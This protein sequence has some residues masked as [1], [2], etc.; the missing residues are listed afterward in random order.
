MRQ[1]PQNVIILFLLLVAELFSILSLEK[2]RERKSPQ[3]T[4]I[5]ISCKISTSSSGSPQY[6]PY[7]SIR[8]HLQR[9]R[10]YFY[11]AIANF[12]TGMVLEPIALGFVVFNLLDTIEKR[13]LQCCGICSYG[14]QRPYFCEK[15]NV[16]NRFCSP[17]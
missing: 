11:K 5:M 16:V 8:A 9:G 14:R 13:L 1:P 10:T 12:K 17:I 4:S 2:F 6:G 3:R 15:Y 7:I